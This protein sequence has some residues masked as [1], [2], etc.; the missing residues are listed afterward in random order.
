M[1][2]SAPLRVL[3]IAGSLRRASTNRGL[4]RAAAET[5]PDGMSVEVFDLAGLPLY[6]ADLDGED[7][8]DPVR[9]LKEAIGGA[10]ALLVACPEYNYG[11]TGVLKNAIDWASRP[12]KDSPLRGK[13]AAILGASTGLMGTV[14]AQLTLR[15]S[16][17]FTRT[18]V[19]PEPEVY[20]NRAGDKFDAAGDLTDEDTRNRVRALL[21]ALEAWVRRL[22]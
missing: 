15:Q 5:A 22:G 6:D 13:P 12:P 20:V 17:L 1:P 4:L 14:R 11:M 18:L 3:G 8:P 9:R 7:P 16:F 21:E 19:L 10:D 2:E